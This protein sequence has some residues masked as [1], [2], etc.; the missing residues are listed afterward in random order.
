MSHIL[1]ADIIPIFVVMILG[2]VSGKK[3]AFTPDQTRSFNKLVLDYALPAAL[4]IS[5]VKANRHMLF[6]NLGLTILSLVGLVIGIVAVVV[7]AVGLGA[8]TMGRN[9]AQPETP[10]ARAWSR[11]LARKLTP[12]TRPEMSTC[13]RATSLSIQ[14]S[15]WERVR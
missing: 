3:N 13:A 5:I 2:Y 6:E 1:V 12:C 15:E 9:L 4:F 14:A 11:V 8:W 10:Q 7:V